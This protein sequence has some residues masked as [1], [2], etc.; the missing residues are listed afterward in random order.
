MS[1]ES[2]LPQYCIEFN[3]PQISIIPGSARD[4]LVGFV[5]FQQ[6]VY[7]RLEV[8][9]TIVFIDVNASNISWIPSSVPN[10]HTNVSSFN[11]KRNLDSGCHADSRLLLKLCKAFYVS[12]FVANFTGL[13]DETE[14][15]PF[16]SVNRRSRFCYRSL[17]AISMSLKSSGLAV[18]SD[19]WGPFVVQELRFNNVL[20]TA[21]MLLQSKVY[22]F[23]LS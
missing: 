19:R 23:R 6:S 16:S 5:P 1:I 15:L 9:H 10:C 4:K 18:T 22:L 2:N 3:L 21:W 13:W 8:N 14:A 12:L 20:F 17:W 7:Q 11:N